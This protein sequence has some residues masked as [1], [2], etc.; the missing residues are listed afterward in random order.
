MVA[1]WFAKLAQFPA[2]IEHRVG[3]KHGNADGL[4]RSCKQC[5]REECPIQYMAELEDQPFLRRGPSVISSE[6][7]DLIPYESG[8]DWVCRV[9]KVERR[10]QIEAS[11]QTIQVAERQISDPEV[12]KVREWVVSGK[13]PDWTEVRQTSK[14]TRALWTQ[15]GRLV[16][17]DNLLY[18]TGT[19]SKVTRQ[20]VLPRCM[21]TLVL[22]EL[23]NS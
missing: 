4:S 13:R 16:L 21:V 20:V 7:L 11:L 1:R 9:L 10:E 15:W 19:G 22:E 2:E 3:R 17:V 8:E 6:D 23:H 18:R 14:G 5:K 12:N